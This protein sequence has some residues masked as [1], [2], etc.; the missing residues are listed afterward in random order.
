MKMYV[1]TR[2]FGRDADGARPTL[3]NHA[4][5]LAEKKKQN[6]LFLVTKTNKL[7]FSPEYER[8]PVFPKSQGRRK[9]KNNVNITIR[10]VGTSGNAKTIDQIYF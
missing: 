8:R 7:S 2:C 1:Q 4:P 9:C 5:I 6:L 10:F 3:H